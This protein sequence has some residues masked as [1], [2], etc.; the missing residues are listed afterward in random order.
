MPGCF[1]RQQRLLRPDQFKRVF[2]KSI[3]VNDAHFSILGQLNQKDSARLGLAIAKKH[4]KKAVGRNRIKRLVRESFRH[5]QEL[6]AGV[7]IVVT[8]RSDA[9]RLTNQVIHERLIQHWH[10]LVTKLK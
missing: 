8:C 2:K 3:R 5:H 9:S 4:I 1:S 7:D 10:N 6:L